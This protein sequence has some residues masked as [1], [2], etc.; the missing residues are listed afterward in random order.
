MAHVPVLCLT[1]LPGFLEF[2]LSLSLSPLAQCESNHLTL[3][4]F[5]EDNSPSFWEPCGNSICEKEL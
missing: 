3:P 1:G 4:L 2:L 5:A